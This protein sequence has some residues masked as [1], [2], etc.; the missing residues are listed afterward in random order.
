MALATKLLAKFVNGGAV[1]LYHNDSKKF[2]TTPNGAVVTG[3]LTATS[4]SG[5]VSALTGISKLGS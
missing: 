2:E 5:D 3:I 1:E 4:F